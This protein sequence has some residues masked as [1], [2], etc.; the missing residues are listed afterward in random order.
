MRSTSQAVET[1]GKVGANPVFLRVASAYM[2]LLTEAIDG[3]VEHGIAELAERAD[4]SGS[5]SQRNELL[6]ASVRLRHEAGSVRDKFLGVAG[7]ALREYCFRDPLSFRKPDVGLASTPSELRVLD[8]SDVAETLACEAAIQRAEQRFSQDLH[9]L[10]LRLGA[11][12]HGDAVD[13]AD[14]PLGPTQLVAALTEAT[15]G[16]IDDLV[17]RLVLIRLFDTRILRHLSV[18]YDPIN[19]LLVEAGIMP[20]IRWEPRL[21]RLRK[22][23]AE[24]SEEARRFAE[25]SSD[26]SATS[27]DE[28]GAG[29]EP[30]SQSSPSS[31]SDRAGDRGVS[32]AGSADAAPGISQPAGES[33]AEPTDAT[34]SESSSAGATPGDSAATPRSEAEGGSGGGAP[35]RAASGGGGSESRSLRR[36][37]LDGWLFGSIQWLLSQRRRMRGDLR[38]ERTPGMAPQILGRVLDEM[39]GEVA[40]SVEVRLQSP[41]ELKSALIDSAGRIAGP[42]EPHNL[43]LADENILDSVGMMFSFMHGDS[44]LPAP[45]QAALAKLQI[46]YL[47]AALADRSLLAE[48]D[49]PAKLLL[50]EM[51]DAGLGWSED[52][53]VGGKILKKVE[54]IVERVLSDYRDDPSLFEALLEEFHGFKRRYERRAE[55]LANREVEA[56]AGRERLQFARRE[57]GRFIVEQT[58]GRELPPLIGE[59][60][61]KSWAHVM[62]I[63]MLTHG[64]HSSQ[65]QQIVKV[66]RELI[67]SVTIKPGREEA[68]LLRSRLPALAK[69]LVQGL[70]KVGYS[71]AE[72]EKLKFRLKRLYS[73]LIAQTG[74][75]RVVIEASAEGLVIHG[76]D[77]TDFDDTELA[78][79]PVIEDGEE[80]GAALDRV[81]AW[82]PGQWVVFHRQGDEPVRAKL[83]WV[84]PITG[85]YLFVNQRGARALER[86]TAELVEDL[87]GERLDVLD[88]EEIVSRAMSAVAS[89]LQEG[90]SREAA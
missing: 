75:D 73:N 17:A 35:S 88:G 1:F 51:A 54:F 63:T 48:A 31:G 87:I 60:V 11:L 26:E 3:L 32:S 36:G 81:Q 12:A 40:R 14:N 74:S 4:M 61:R 47:K 19:E 59:L 69:A 37:Y 49:S 13:E 77:L 27:S 65:W 21:A 72:L 8:D 53:D 68:Q 90:M 39:Q 43:T 76:E 46:P 58:E 23:V 16:S 41:D 28:S 9:C 80:L 79:M 67:W 34:G 10:G 22:S 6:D 5:D 89:K 52:S 15:R 64:R 25:G 62:V 29:Q 66:T 71:D 44:Q 82:K 70:R 85:R 55:T 78:A 86:S 50:N 18:L 83:S 42:K 56:A 2:A 57:V 24:R 84:S 45:F 20:H 30:P 38:D 7:T 33:G